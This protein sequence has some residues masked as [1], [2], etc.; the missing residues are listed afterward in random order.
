[1]LVA[2]PF[3]VAASSVGLGHQIVGDRMV[4]LAGSQRG[5]VVDCAGL[6]VVAVA[7]QALPQTVGDVAA[8]DLG[9]EVGSQVTAAL[10][11]V[12]ARQRSRA[13]RVRVRLRG[14]PINRGGGGDDRCRTGRA[15]RGNSPGPVR[16]GF[17]QQAARVALSV[18]GVGPAGG[19]GAHRLRG[20]GQLGQHLVG[21]AGVDGRGGLV[22]EGH[23][24][25]KAVT[26]RG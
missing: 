25:V 26:L 12:V 24:R 8:S 3:G 23:D 18:V 13:L 11:G 14:V 7:A 15:E 1:M 16:Q 6:W 2:A 5:M 19:L 22:E 9:K 21:D 20:L 10:V 17:G 4:G